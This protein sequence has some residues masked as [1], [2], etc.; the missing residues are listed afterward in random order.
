M[1]INYNAFIFL[2]TEK[3]NKYRVMLV[4]PTYST[5]KS[6]GIPGGKSDNTFSMSETPLMTMQRE[7]NEETTNII[8]TDE[9]I[10]YNFKIFYY[11]PTNAYIYY[12]IIPHKKLKEGPIYNSYMD[13][14]DYIYNLDIK[15]IFKYKN[16]KLIFNNNYTIKFRNNIYYPLRKAMIN[17]LKEMIKDKKFK[18]FIIDLL[19]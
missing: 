15:K 7:F 14:I 13:E 8:T 4:R 16:N 9:L 12:G 2:V 18:R 1:D 5:N 3:N 6:F 10:L 17:S 19:V 11:E